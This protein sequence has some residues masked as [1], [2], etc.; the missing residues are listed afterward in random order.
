MLGNGITEVAAVIDVAVQRDV[1]Q[2]N[3]ETQ[4]W[5]WTPNGQHVPTGLLATSSGIAPILS[6]DGGA[7]RTRESGEFFHQRTEDVSDEYLVGY[8]LLETASK[9]LPDPGE[10]GE[11]VGRIHC[12]STS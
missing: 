1:E 2:P 9:D 12:C 6:A 3:G 7:A 4:V 11:Q 10:K 5:R 8:L